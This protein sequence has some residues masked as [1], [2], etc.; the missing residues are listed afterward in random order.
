[1]TNYDLLP[2][3]FSAVH[4]AVIGTDG[5]TIIFANPAAETAFGDIP[6][7]SDAEELLPKEL[8]ENKAESFICA[9]T[10]KDKQA[11]M[12]VF[13]DGELTLLFID[14]ISGEQAPLFMSRRI[15][16]SLRNSAMGLKM[17][18]DHCF[19]KLDEGTLPSEKHISMLYHYYYRLLRTITQ[20]DS[21]DLIE[22]GDLLFSPVLT[23]LVRLCGDLTDTVSA[24]NAGSGISI[25]FST[26]EGELTAAVDPERMEQLLLNLFANSLKHCERGSSITVS[27]RRAGDRAVISVDDN[28]EGIP[29]DTL[30]NIFA[31]PSAEADLLTPESGS[32]LGLYIAYG[33]AQLHKGVLLI[34]SRQGEGTHVR[35]MLPMDE[36]P[37]P[38]FS[39]PE[40]GYKR[41]VSSVLTGLAEV[42]G[43]D[44]FGPKLED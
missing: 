36:K 43:N 30:S 41:S 26:P 39:T 8:L 37:A 9:A 44:C 6:A 1:M 28:G 24:L 4:Q 7:G 12:S 10:I 35:L 32:G 42:L 2:K 23:D 40:T 11:A 21:A 17:S 33:I 15:I 20:V 25:S 13:R 34:E 27:L 16:S 14:L 19:F 31:P 38:K 29:R 5:K 22:R 18:A 3:L